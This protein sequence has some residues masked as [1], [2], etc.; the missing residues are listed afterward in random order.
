VVT[1]V[2]VKKRVYSMRDGAAPVKEPTMEAT[3]KQ[4]SLPDPLYPSWL[5]R[6]AHSTKAISVYI[7]QNQAKLSII[8]RR[9][10]SCNVILPRVRVVSLTDSE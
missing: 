2:A 4:Q 6:S 5:N 1:V 9:P 3:D 7:V 8:E 10:Y